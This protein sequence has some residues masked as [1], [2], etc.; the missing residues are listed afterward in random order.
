M[1]HTRTKT[2]SCCRRLTWKLVPLLF[3]FAG[4]TTLYAH[5]LNVFAA[6]EGDQVTGYAYFPGGGRAAAVEVTVTADDGR[7]LAVL[8]TDTDGVFTYRPDIA[9]GLKFTVQSVD[10]HRAV[11]TVAADPRAAAVAEAPPAD[12]TNAVNP[13]LPDTAP[14]PAATLTATVVADLISREIRPLREEVAAYRSEV[15]LHDVI[16][17]LGYITGLAGLVMYMKAK[18]ILKKAA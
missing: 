10:G 1:I 14:P 9:G 6:W 8:R 5:K 11:Y 16:G 12:K 4:A 2:W 7:E 3:L 15:R 13:L 17:G 18:K